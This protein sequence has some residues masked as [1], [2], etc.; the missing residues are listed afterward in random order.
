MYTNHL[1]SWLKR[2]GSSR[3]YPQE[4]VEQRSYRSCE[5]FISHLR[6]FYTKLLLLIKEEDL[7]DEKGDWFKAANDVAIYLPVLEMAGKKIAYLP[8]ITYLYNDMTGLNNY[9]SKRD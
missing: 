5:F 3:K 2:I 8:E 6:A 7:K 9:E 1:G 4:V